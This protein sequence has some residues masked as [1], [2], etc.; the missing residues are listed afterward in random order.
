MTALILTLL[1]L[2]F[3][4]S[5]PALEENANFGRSSLAAKIAPGLRTAEQAGITAAEAQR[6]Q[7]A[8]NRLGKPINVVGSR[9]KGTAGVNSDWD[10]VVTGANRSDFNKIKN[11][12]PGAPNRLDGTPRNLEV[13]KGE[14]DPNLPHVP[15]NPQP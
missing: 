2:L 11:S 10:Y 7:N 13:F 14:L 1:T 4:S 12:L 6:I 3:S 5:S 15:F 8:A 9:A